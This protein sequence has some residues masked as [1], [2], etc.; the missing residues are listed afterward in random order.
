M[1]T[2]AR[3]PRATTIGMTKSKTLEIVVNQVPDSPTTFDSSTCAAGRQE[4]P[5]FEVK[6]FFFEWFTSV[7]FSAIRDEVF[8]R[9][10]TRREEPR[11]WESAVFCA[12]FCVHPIFLVLGSRLCLGRASCAYRIDCTLCDHLAQRALE[13][14]RLPT[15]QPYD[16]LRRFSQQWCHVKNKRHITLDNGARWSI[17][18]NRT[19]LPWSKVSQAQ[20][21]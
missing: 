2:I 13:R 16:H 1:M 3:K 11:V 5:R 15:K 7:S 17:I 20:N 12:V 8:F 21:D 19:H 4:T 18:L 14:N 9:T 10:R 6:S